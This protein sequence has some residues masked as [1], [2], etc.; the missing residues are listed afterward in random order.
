M[1]Q[2]CVAHSYRRQGIATH[3]WSA[4][5]K[6][7]LT[8]ERKLYVAYSTSS[9]SST[10]D[11]AERPLQLTCCRVMSRR[12][13]VSRRSGSLSMVALY[14]ALLDNKARCMINTFTL[15][16]SQAQHLT[17]H[18]SHFQLNLQTL[19][20]RLAA[21]K[22]LVS[23]SIFPTLLSAMRSWPMCLAVSLVSHI[24]VLTNASLYSH[25]GMP[26]AS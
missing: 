10:F 7:R 18:K 19:S 2:C 8:E 13:G 21:V 5:L 11:R 25:S 26:G 4:I 3:M 24:I 15:P 20:Q 16:S 6:H 1:L 22:H 17:S 14:M 12:T 9:S 23:N